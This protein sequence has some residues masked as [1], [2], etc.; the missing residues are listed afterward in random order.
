MGKTYFPT[1]DNEKQLWS[2]GHRR[3]GG[4]L[5]PVLF[6]WTFY[7]TAGRLNSNVLRLGP[8]YRVLSLVACL[9]CKL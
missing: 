1:R 7:C 4:E 6:R 2:F 9:Y 3:I 5:L 8:T